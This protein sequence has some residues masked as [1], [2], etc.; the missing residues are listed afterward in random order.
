MLFNKSIKKLILASLLVAIPAQIMSTSRSFWNMAGIALSATITTIFIGKKY[1]GRK[2]EEAR[3][4]KRR[5]YREELSNYGANVAVREIDE[6]PRRR[7]EARE[8]L[9]I[10]YPFNF[11]IPYPFNFQEV[12]RAI[13]RNRRDPE[14]VK[15]DFYNRVKA[16]IETIT[17]SINSRNNVAGVSDQHLSENE[18]EICCICFD[19][20]FEEKLLQGIPCGRGKNHPG[21][22][23]QNCLNKARIERDRCPICRHEGDI[24][25]EGNVEQMN[26]EELRALM[27]NLK[28][29]IITR[30]EQEEEIGKGLINELDNLLEIEISDK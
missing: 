23:H 6:G 4:R 17:Q 14:R 18:S 22:I 9:E 26:T 29:A 30:G 10:P 8:N 25:H 21:K 1:L 24:I 16:L 3:G 27:F 28:K 12:G 5:A 13:E 11:E 20:D 2:R 19:N 15:A 7:E